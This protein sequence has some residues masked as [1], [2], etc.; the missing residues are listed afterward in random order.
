MP[1]PAKLA[2]A[3]IATEDEHF[4]DNVVFNVATGAGRAGAA[5]H[6]GV[7]HRLGPAGRRRCAFCARESRVDQRNAVAG[8]SV[9]IDYDNRTG[10]VLLRLDGA[11]VRDI[12][13]K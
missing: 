3:A 4:D 10:V 9:W 2:A 1:V 7:A 12:C 5:A 13:P 8:R 6:A 11:R